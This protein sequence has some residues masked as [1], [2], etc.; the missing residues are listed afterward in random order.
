MSFSSLHTFYSR[1]HTLFVTRAAAEAASKQALADWASGKKGEEDAIAAGFVSQRGEWEGYQEQEYIFE[2]V[3][4]KV[5]DPTYLHAM[6]QGP[7]LRLLA[8]QEN[9][10][11]WA[12]EGKNDPS[13]PTFEL[14]TTNI[15][16]NAS[17]KKHFA[18]HPRCGPVE[19]NADEHE[20]MFGG[21]MFGEGMF[22]EGMFGGGMFGGTEVGQEEYDLMD[23]VFVCVGLVRK[24]VPLEGDEHSEMLNMV[25]SQDVTGTD[26]GNLALVDT[27]IKMHEPDINMSFAVDHLLRQ[28]YNLCLAEEDN[29]QGMAVL[30]QVLR[31]LGQ[32]GFNMAHQDPRGNTLLHRLIQIQEHEKIQMYEHFDTDHPEGRLCIVDGGWFSKGA[33]VEAIRFA[34]DTCVGGQESLALQNKQGDTVLDVLN[35][36]RE[37]F[38][39]FMEVCSTEE[40]RQKCRHEF[41]EMGR[42]LRIGVSV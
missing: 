5:F 23:L 4:S 21:G 41:E 14:N 37:R 7:T 33:T 42:L 39:K 8:L 13:L 10:E 18:Q 29:E 36:R 40:A 16:L 30:N 22:G 20:N 2:H 25:Y 6:L 38:A 32:H 12:K 28:S 11:T 15:R 34:L 26:Y 35:R 31:L 1:T 17:S 9:S 19:N 3:Q 27:F 24:N